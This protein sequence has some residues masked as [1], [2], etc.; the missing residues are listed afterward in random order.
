MGGNIF[1]PKSYLILTTI[2]SKYHIFCLFYKHMT[3]VSP[4]MLWHKMNES[5][6]KCTHQILKKLSELVLIFLNIN[7]K[8]SNRG[9]GKHGYYLSLANSKK[10]C[11]IFLLWIVD[12]PSW[13]MLGSTLATAKIHC[14]KTTTQTSVLIFVSPSTF[15]IENI[16]YLLYKHLFLLK[17]W[18]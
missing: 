3:Y 14:Q 9:T 15:Y 2:G 6:K 17:R 18:P 7:L 16:N 10:F 13:S 11:T 12:L 8:R 1:S 5:W 4:L